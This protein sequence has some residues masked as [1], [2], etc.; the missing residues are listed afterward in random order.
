MNFL[1][2][3][4][5]VFAVAGAPVTNWELTNAVVTYHVDHPLHKVDGISKEARGKGTC[6]N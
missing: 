6:K 3:F 5:S 4:Y 2:L 1:I